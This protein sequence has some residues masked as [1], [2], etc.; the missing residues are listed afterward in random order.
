[1]PTL[2]STS[3]EKLNAYIHNCYT[4]KDF[5]ECLKRIDEQLRL[6][7]GQSEYPLYIKGIIII[8]TI[9]INQ[10]YN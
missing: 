9:Y 7:N 6:S 8:L 5:N 4:K 1:M 10:Y 3:R 2:S